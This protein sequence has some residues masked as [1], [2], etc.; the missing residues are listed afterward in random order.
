MPRRYPFSAATVGRGNAPAPRHRWRIAPIALALMLIAAACGGD[1]D[2]GSGSL[3]VY[4]GRNE[5]LIQPLIDTFIDETG[6]EV[7]VRYGDSAE[8]AATI[9]EEGDNSPADVFIA[10]DPASLGVVALD[11][12]LTTLPDD[13]L[14]RVPDSLEDVDGHWVG[15]SGR[16]RVV[17]YDTTLVDPADLPADENGFTDPEWAGRVGLAPTNGSFLSFVS[18]K[19]LLD[20]EEATLEWLQ[21]MAANDSP[22]FPNNSSIVAG[23]NDGQVETGLVNHYYWYR[24]A[25][26]LGAENV[27]AANHFLPGPGSSTAP[28][29]LTEPRR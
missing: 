3:T 23:V 28:Q 17:V 13:I 2:A 4:S 5:E 14:D 9:L 25:D 27:D 8:L 26:E 22:T 10:Q 15:I 12:L 11:G 16:S 29:T 21:A 6:V 7:E 19:I 20:G 24:L 18:A 1:D